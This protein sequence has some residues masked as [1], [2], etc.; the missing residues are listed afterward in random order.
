M[1]LFLFCFFIFFNFVHHWQLLC[2]LHFV[3]FPDPPNLL[4]VQITIIQSFDLL[5]FSFHP[6]FLDFAFQVNLNLSFVVWSF[7]SFHFFLLV[8]VI[9][10]K[11][12]FIFWSFHSFHPFPLVLAIHVEISLSVWFYRSFHL[13]PLLLVIHVKLSFIFW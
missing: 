1:H 7:H 4:T 11:V 3:D 9:H 5:R 8:F 13:F 6:F 12:S 2:F 10:V